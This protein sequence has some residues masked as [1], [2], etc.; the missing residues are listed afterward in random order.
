M[1]GGNG[2]TDLN[3]FLAVHKLQLEAGGVPSIYWSSL[4]SK[5]TKQVFDAGSQFRLLQVEVN[6]NTEY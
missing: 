6:V 1:T 3:T 2:V 4:H 5:L